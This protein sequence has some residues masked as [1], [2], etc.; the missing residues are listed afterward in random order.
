VF[1]LIADATGYSLDEAKDAMRWLFL[2][3]EHDILP[4]TVRSTTEL[5]T[6]EFEE[7]MAACRRW[8]SEFLG[9]YIPE[10]NEVDL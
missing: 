5:D 1:K 10:P 7:F 9:L 3:E 6:Q 4:P 8:A 2:R